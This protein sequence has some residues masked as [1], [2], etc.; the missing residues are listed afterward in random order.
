M[1]NSNKLNP[2]YKMISHIL[3]TVNSSLILKCLGVLIAFYS[4]IAGVLL[5]VGLFI[6]ADTVT[7][8]WK[9]IKTGKRSSKKMRQGLVP[10]MLLYQSAILILFVLDFY[11]LGGIVSIFFKIPYLVTKIGALVL[12]YIEL[13][14]IDENWTIIKGKSLWSSMLDM[15][16]KLK[17]VKSNVDSLNKTPESPEDVTI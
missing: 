9:A 12:I 5:C 4:P 15:F 6:F 10:K 11:I 17:T 3:A 16:K 14:S 13:T 8:V 2:Y 1:K 7:G